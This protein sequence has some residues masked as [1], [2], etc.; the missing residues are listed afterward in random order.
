LAVVVGSVAV[1]LMML[2]SVRR[3]IVRV[4]ERQRLERTRHL[5]DPNQ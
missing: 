4:H 1:Y 5:G 2:D 3:G